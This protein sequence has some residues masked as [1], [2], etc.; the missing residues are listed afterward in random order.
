MIIDIIKHYKL[1]KLDKRF[2]CPKNYVRNLLLEFKP[3][4]I[5]HFKDYV[6]FTY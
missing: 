2:F 4:F 5:A 1:H 6:T 3:D